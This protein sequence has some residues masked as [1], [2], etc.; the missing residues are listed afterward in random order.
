MATTSKAASRSL[1]QPD[2]HVEKG[3]VQIDVVHLGDIKVK[4]A[5][6]PA[7]WR[8]SKDMGADS[9]QDNHVGYV[10]DGEIHAVLDDGTELDTKAG[11]VFIVPAG[12]DA[13]SENGCTIVQF[14]EF[15]AAARRFGLS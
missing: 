11:D 1:D 14:D 2:E 10:I 3:G 8:F 15:D 7:G 4:R 9:C 12:H 5:K 6:Y 13:W